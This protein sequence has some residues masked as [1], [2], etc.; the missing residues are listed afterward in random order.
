MS[1]HT[2]FP[3]ESRAERVRDLGLLTLESAREGDTHVILLSGELDI[4]SSPEV[5][6]ELRRVEATDA[7]AIVLDLSGLQFVDSTGLRLLIQAEQRSRWDAGRLSLKR[8]PGRV[9]RV[10]E[11]AGIDKLLP[12]DD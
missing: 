5:D 6:K 10:F 2:P 7:D 9:Q 12:F 1:A 4:M 8:P 3:P 11:I